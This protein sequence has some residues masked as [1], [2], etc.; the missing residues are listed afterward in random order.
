[1]LP[2][3]LDCSFVIVPSILSNVYLLSTTMNSSLIVL[4][5]ALVM[6]EFLN[7][8]SEKIHMTYKMV[9]IIY[10]RSFI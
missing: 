1:M 2:V 9:S 8:T 10:R 6:T 7:F 5:L 3:S 4:I